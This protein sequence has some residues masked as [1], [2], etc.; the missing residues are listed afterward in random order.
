MA[1]SYGTDIG[2]NEATKTKKAGMSRPLNGDPTHVGLP[3]T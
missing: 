2:K 1:V 3:V